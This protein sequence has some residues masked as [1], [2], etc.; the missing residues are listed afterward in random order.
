MW[1]WLFNLIIENIWIIFIFICFIV[2]YGYLNFMQSKEILW[3]SIYFFSTFFILIW[4]LVEKINLITTYFF[5]QIVEPIIVLDPT[6]FTYNYFYFVFN[7]CFMLIFYLLYF[8][9]YLY[10]QQIYCYYNNILFFFFCIVVLY[11]SA[12]IFWIIKYDL[13]FSNWF[14]FSYMP[15]FSLWFDFQPDIE[16]FLYFFWLDY[17]EFFIFSF[18]IYFLISFICI[19]GY[20]NFLLVNRGYLQIILFIVLSTNLYFFSELNFKNDFLLCLFTYGISICLE[21]SLYFLYYLRQYKRI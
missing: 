16:K 10:L 9:I 4:F 13:F 12:I 3:F 6:V 17:W 8:Y 21:I 1:S 15:K 20:L 19:Q 14:S 5:N 2:W 7:C 18:G 11:Y